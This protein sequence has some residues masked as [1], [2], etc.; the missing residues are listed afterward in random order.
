MEQQLNLI[1]VNHIPFDLDSSFDSNTISK[2]RLK[3]Y[4]LKKN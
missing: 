4:F 3:K 2:I 1:Y